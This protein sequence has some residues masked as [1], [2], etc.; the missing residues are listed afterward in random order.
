MDEALFFMA[1]GDRMYIKA[2]GHVTA[3]Y[4]PDLKARCFARF[5]D[6]PPVAGVA[7]D[8]SECEYMD[9]TFL[10]LIVGLTKRLTA[11]SGRKVNIFGISPTCVG[12]LK[13][14]GVLKL[15]EIVETPEDFPARLDQV[16]RTATATAQFL[17]DTHEEL[18]SL[19]DENRAKFAALNGM[20]RESI[21]HPEKEDS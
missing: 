19:S 2:T 10:G 17:L 4:C 13:T 5:D 15:I 6:R 11:D 3:T 20:L 18:A 12:L 14:I 21:A 9:S 16:G 8:L 7:I 1:T